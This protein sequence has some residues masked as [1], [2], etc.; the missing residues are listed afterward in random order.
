MSVLEANS[1]KVT[2]GDTQVCQDLDL[3]IEPGER[4]CILGR[5]G[6]GKTTLLHTLAGLRPADSGSIEL[7]ASGIMLR[8]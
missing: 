4:W 8:S 1:L 2:I 6:T 7:N 5:N 3:R